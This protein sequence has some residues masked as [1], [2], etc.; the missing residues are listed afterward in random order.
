MEPQLIG[1]RVDSL[2]TLRGQSSGYDS[3]LDEE[4][5]APEIAVGPMIQSCIQGEETK[6]ISIVYGMINN[7]YAYGFTSIIKTTKH[8]TKIISIVYGTMNMFMLM[9]L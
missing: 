2:Y 7:V 3:T 9:V 1:D 5:E 8:V 4:H 6:I